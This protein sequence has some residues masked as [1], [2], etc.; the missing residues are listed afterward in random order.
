MGKIRYQL[1]FT[2]QVLI[3]LIVCSG[4]GLGQAPADSLLERRLTF[5]VEQA[6]LLIAVGI[7]AAE[8]RVPIGFER[9][10]VSTG[11]V[12]HD[13]DVRNLTLAEILNLITQ[14]WPIYRWEVQDGVVNFI[15]R[16]TRDPIVEELLTT[17]IDHFSPRKGLNRFELRDAI[18]DLPEVK[19]FLRANDVSVFRLGPPDPLHVVNGAVD[20]SAYGTDVKGVLNKIVKETDKKFWLAGRIDK[21]T[22]QFSF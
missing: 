9:S 15:P 13:I 19:S 20:L 4:N 10:S 8:H 6:T 7:L 22:L 18:I 1:L 16:D 2:I 21:N 3:L 5:K 17:R 14:Y 12:R 11:D